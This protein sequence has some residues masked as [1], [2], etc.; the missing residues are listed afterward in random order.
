MGHVIRSL[1][2]ARELRS[3][4]GAQCLFWCNSDPK[5]RERVHAAEFECVGGDAEADEAQPLAGLLAE[6]EVD[7]VVLDQPGELQELTHQ[8]RARVPRTFL[9]TLDYFNFDNP[10]PSLIINLLNHNPH[11]SRPERSTI[12]YFEGPEFGIL[13]SGFE[14]FLK[15]RKS[16]PDR[17]REI[18]VTFGGSD[19]NRNMIRVIQALEGR[20][21]EGARF[22]FVIGPNFTHAQ[23]V[24]QA[25]SRL[26]VHAQVHRQPSDY[27]R[28]VFESDMAISGSGTTIVEMA[29][30]GT[31]LLA[32]PQS[33]EELRFAQLFERRGSAVC[34]GLG[35]EVAPQAIWEEI[36]RLSFDVGAREQMSL[37]G[38]SI[39]DGLGRMRVAAL[40]HQ[41]WSEMRG[42][43]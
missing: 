43:S 40:I 24:A 26:S 21:L 27:E 31:P 8:I 1:E 42:S 18:V 5:A 15:L 4:Q 39:V 37:A 2:L 25:A 34:L 6:R 10:D 14:P 30:L 7:C 16:A 11:K 9:T 29:A 38:R 41:G 13:R 28:L 35:A 3:Q 22:H 17:A 36:E 12:R 19:P 20:R 32:L 23:E 33:P